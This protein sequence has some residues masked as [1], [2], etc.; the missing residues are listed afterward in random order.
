[1]T[2]AVPAPDGAFAYYNRFVV[3]GQHPLYCRMPREGGDEQILLDGNALAKPHAYFRI[4]GVTHSPDHKL[5]AYAVDTKGSEFYA[6]N[7]IEAATG[8]LLDVPH[9]RLQR[10]AG[11]GGRQPYATV[12][13]AG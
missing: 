1:M 4:S 9:R 6:V 7:V 8:A 5:I 2:P 11:M 3:G 10:V 13:M 12:H